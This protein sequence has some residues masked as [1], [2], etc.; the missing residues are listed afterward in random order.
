M[1]GD[2]VHARALILIYPPVF[3]GLSTWVLR[4]SKHVAEPIT[5]NVHLREL[6]GWV[7]VESVMVGIGGVALF[8]CCQACPVPGQTLLPLVIAWAASSAV[9]NLFFWLPATSLLRDGALVLA[10]TPS[11]PTSVA[12]LF[13]LL[14]RV[15]DCFFAADRGSFGCGW[16]ARS[17]S[18]AGL[19]DRRHRRQ[20][21]IR[22]HGCDWNCFLR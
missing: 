8:F 14:A 10:L 22:R 16:T 19:S 6:I 1:G 20:V 17:G 21:L 18:R 11:L 5:I 7:L 2:W 4:R 13:A 12:I 3:N 9:G 15:V